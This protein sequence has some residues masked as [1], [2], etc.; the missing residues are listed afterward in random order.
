M[1]LIGHFRVSYRQTVGSFNR[2]L[3][4]A[5]DSA[6]HPWDRVWLLVT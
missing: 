3:R 6:G 1:T 4:R 2:Q 5:T